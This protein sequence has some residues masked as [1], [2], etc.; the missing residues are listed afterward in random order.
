MQII[1]RGSKMVR[2]L[3]QALGGTP[4]KAAVEKSRR[5]LQQVTAARFK[6]QKRSRDEMARVTKPM[7]S[8]MFSHIAKSDP[9]L[10]KSIEDM[11]GVCEHRSKRKIKAPRAEKF[12]PHFAVGS[13]F[14]LKAPPYDTPW[15]FKSP[16][17]SASADA[18]AGTYNLAAQSFGDGSGESAA[19]LGVWFLAPADTP[20][21][22][23]AAVIDYSDDWWDFASGYV[24]HNDLRTRLWVWGNTENRWVI[25]SDT[26]LGWSDGVSWFESH[27]ND[28]QGDAGRFSAETFF[29]ASANN[30][31]LAWIWSDASVDSDDGFWGFSASSIQLSISVPL[32]VFGSLF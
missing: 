22:R 29:P 14:W 1:A 31:Y 12:E 8:L 30:W 11:K 19:G 7:Q 9:K 23:F 32:V 4:P 18:S 2:D 20:S 6:A 27:G 16:T 3:E 26:W 10:K 24:A 28:P 17:N 25:Q 5:E 21:Q 15:T 13:N